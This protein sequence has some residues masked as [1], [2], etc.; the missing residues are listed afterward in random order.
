MTRKKKFIQ[1][2]DLETVT[3]MIIDEEELYTRLTHLLLRSLNAVAVAEATT[4]AEFT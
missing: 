4:Y 3:L 1:L 2:I